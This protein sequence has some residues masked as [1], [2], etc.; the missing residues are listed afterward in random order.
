MS[1]LQGFGSQSHIVTLSHNGMRYKIFRIDFHTDG[2]I[3][4]NFP[5]Y[6]NSDGI[7]SKVHMH[8]A[9]QNTY[10]SLSL[11]DEARVT[12][13]RVKYSHH[14]TGEALFSMDGKVRTEIR[15][16]SVPLSELSGHIFTVQIQGFNGFEEAR[17]KKYD[18][19]WSEARNTIHF[20]LQGNFP[21]LKFVATW[22]R[23]SDFIKDLKA[24]IGIETVGPQIVYN[25]TKDKGIGFIL[26]P[27]L[28]NPF[29][30]YI[31]L[32]R[33]HI[34]ERI[35]KDRN[36]ILAF[37]GGFDPINKM[38]DLSQEAT[39]L[40]LVYPVAHLDAIKKI[41]LSMDFVKPS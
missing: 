40:S 12:S 33:V 27:N 32:L 39:F 6:K 31:L 15:K 7:A 23:S 24:P 28:N 37:I 36:S 19:G 13:H 11:T 1:T 18:H 26:S 35:D 41:L 21:A 4:V 25:G 17:G 38:N 2:S 29:S 16:Q 22:E 30:D 9:N 10:D 8:P 14:T 3:F 5:Y 34:I 20:D